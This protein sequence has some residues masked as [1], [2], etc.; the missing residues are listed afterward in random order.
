MI[1]M[2]MVESTAVRKTSQVL[3][4]RDSLATRTA[5]GHADYWSFRDAATARHE[6][7]VLFQY[8]AM[9]VS[10]MQGALIDV[11]REHREGPLAIL[12]P[13]VG[14]GT[15]LIEA[16]RRGLPFTGTDLNPFAVM[17]AR[18]ESAEAAAFDIGASLARVLLTLDDA[19]GRTAPP[20]DQWTKRWFRQDVCGELA[21]LQSAIRTEPQ[22]ELRRLWWACMAEVCRLSGNARLSTPKLQ[23]RPLGDLARPIDVADRFGQLAERAA[24]VVA[25]RGDALTQ[26]GFVTR[27]GSYRPGVTLRLADARDLPVPPVLA[28][29]VLTSPPY[30]DNH[31]TMPYGQASFLP[32][33]WIDR[34]DT[35]DNIPAEL[36]A[37]SRSLDTA[38]LGGS[39]KTAEAEPVAVVA[40]QSEALAAVLDRL[41]SHSRDGWQ[42]VGSFFVDYA[43]AWDS[44]L[45]ACKPDAHL[46]LTLGDRT[47]RGLHVPTAL[48]TQELL[49]SRGVELVDTLH[50]SIPRN[51]RIA[52]R[53]ELS[54][55]IGS[56]TVLVMQRSGC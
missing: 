41:R 27:R 3:A 16:M 54:D 55:T 7:D 50:R 29:L 22:P 34:E 8:P 37:S 49:E 19:R 42:R 40:H 44:I 32:L 43:A 14:S 5:D 35:A 33:C 20:T 21:A 48:I 56:E 13:F 31:T 6:D 12:D 10:P 2:G 28:D 4:L 46:V 18:V 9:M 36:L 17:L 52:K 15:T 24:S 25:R 51:K 39:R 23:T 26:A 30:G 53:N 11:L 1:Y 45:S 47:V 38:C